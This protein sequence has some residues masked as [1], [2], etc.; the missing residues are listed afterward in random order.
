MNK[1]DL[2]INALTRALKQSLVAT[3]ASGAA[4]NLFSGLAPG[5][6]PPFRE[7]NRKGRGGEKESAK[8][9]FFVVL[10]LI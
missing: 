1:K 10:F 5:V 6:E 4:K 7:E 9:R 3:R 8:S 2:S